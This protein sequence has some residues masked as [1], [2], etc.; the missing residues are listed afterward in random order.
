[1]DCELGG[2]S[3]GSGG[4][5]FS[6]VNPNPDGASA[7]ETKGKKKAMNEDFGSFI[8][9]LQKKGQDRLYFKALV[10]DRRLHSGF[11]TWHSQQINQGSIRISKQRLT[12]SDLMPN[13]TR[14]S[15]EAMN[16][17]LQ[18]PDKTTQKSKNPVGKKND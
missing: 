15:A 6:G 9:V 8:R 18:D 12:Q 10:P 14:Q 7:A 1:V 4:R 11:Q 17:Q 3:S 5:E 2:A 16:S 13:F